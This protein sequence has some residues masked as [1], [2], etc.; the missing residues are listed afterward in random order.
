MMA[1]QPSH[2]EFGVPD[3]ARAKRFYGDLLGWEFHTTKGEWAW[4]E[5]GGVGG[6]VHD[7]G[8][9]RDVV[10][11]FFVVDIDA[12]VRRVRDLGGQA[13]DPGPPTSGGRYASCR[14][15]QR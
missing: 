8:D 6:G 3:A 7:G 5:T 2:F 12:A 10:L 15:C 1:G 11:Y 14:D 4:I 9:E 13:E